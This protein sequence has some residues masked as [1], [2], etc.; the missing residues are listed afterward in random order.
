MPRKGPRPS[1]SSIKRNSQLWLLG[2]CFTSLFPSSLFILTSRS[3]ALFNEYATYGFYAVQIVVFLI[4][5][6][7]ASRLK[8]ERSR[9]R[10]IAISAVATC[11]GAVCTIMSQTAGAFPLP[12]FMLGTVLAA[13]GNAILQ[14]CWMNQ[15]SHLK[16]VHIVIGYSGAMLA[17]SVIQWLLALSPQAISAMAIALSPLLSAAMLQAARMSDR[18][19]ETIESSETHEWSFPYRPVLLFGLFSF[20]YKVSLNLLPEAD[21]A[22]AIAIGTL[23]GAVAILSAA[24]LLQK[25]FDIR[26]LYTTSLPCAIAGLVCVMGALY[27]PAD[28]G[29]ALIVMARELFTVFMVTILCN[30][31]FRNGIDAFWLFGLLNA[32]SRLASLTANWVTLVPLE[33][34]SEQGV[35]VFLAITAVLFVCVFMAFVSDR[36]TETTWGIRKKQAATPEAKTD[37]DIALHKMGRSC[38]LTLREEEVALLKLQGITV[39]EIADRLY[40]S[41]ATVKTHVN[42]IYHK[43]DTHSVEELT[44]LVEQYR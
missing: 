27:I 29:V 8:E 14:L 20:V 38:N 31:C 28:I 6:L 17:S 43:T 41:Q 16:I 34:S 21:K 19:A 26:L 7:M 2:L 9:T 4:L 33:K 35:Y 12:L 5:A 40:I 24:T 37:M 32:A 18:E 23:I 25:K 42:R 11:L 1:H 15:Y 39:A 10:L 3:L 22:A 13:S 30:I 44:E 36:S